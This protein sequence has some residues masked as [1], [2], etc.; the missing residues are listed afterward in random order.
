MVKFHVCLCSVRLILAAQ[1]AL[2]CRVGAESLSL[3][4]TLV[5][6]VNCCCRLQQCTGSSGWDLLQNMQILGAMNNLRSI[7]E[8]GERY[9]GWK[10]RDRF[11]IR[12]V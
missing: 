3:T 1:S 4:K 7:G 10:E 8:D 11:W 9:C 5:I 2:T 6:L 12:G